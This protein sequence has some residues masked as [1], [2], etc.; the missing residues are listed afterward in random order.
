MLTLIIVVVAAV[1]LALAFGSSLTW[2]FMLLGLSVKTPQAVQG[3]GFMVIMPLQFGSSIFAPTQT[4]PGWLQSFTAYN[5]LSRLADAARALTSGEGAVAHPTMI[6]LV[7]TV[8]I[9]AVMAPLAVRK[10]RA[11]T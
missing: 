10:F 1:V 9:T 6:V 8:A 2:I 7:W 11:R 3:I 4:M 5:P